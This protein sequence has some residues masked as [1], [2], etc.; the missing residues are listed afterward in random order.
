MTD[1]WIELTNKFRQNKF[2]IQS[3]RKTESEWVSECVSE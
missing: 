3:G 2:A 1:I